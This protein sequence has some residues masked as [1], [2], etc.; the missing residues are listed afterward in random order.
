[1]PIGGAWRSPVARLLWEQE[2]PSSNLGAP[3]I[4]FD[5]TGTRPGFPPMAKDLDG[6]LR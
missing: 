4:H 2:V 6:A 1:M 5:S 3:T